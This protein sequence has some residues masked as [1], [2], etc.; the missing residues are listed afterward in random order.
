MSTILRSPFDSNPSLY[1]IYDDYISEII[2]ENYEHRHHESTPSLQLSLEQ[3]REET[4]PSPNSG[5]RVLRE[6]SSQFHSPVQVPLKFSNTQY[7]CTP[8]LEPIFA[9]EIRNGVQKEYFDRSSLI[10]LYFGS[11]ISQSSSRKV[12]PLSTETIVPV[13][14]YISRPLSTA[15]NSSTRNLKIW[16]FVGLIC[17]PVWIVGGVQGYYSKKEFLTETNRSLLPHRELEKLRKWS[18][19]NEL[20]AMIVLIVVVILLISVPL[21]NRK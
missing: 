10:D 11:K 19:V 1:S 13:R 5:H 15:L 8:P 17:P 7:G 12:S 3:R 2:L 4:N 14:H 20:L 21:L 9:N 18:L 6:S 16:F